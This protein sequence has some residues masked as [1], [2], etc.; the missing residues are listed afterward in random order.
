MGI[1]LSLGL[2]EVGD[3]Q[4]SCV[5][6][7]NFSIDYRMWFEALPSLFLV[8][9]FVCAPYAIVPLGQKLVNGNMYGRKVRDQHYRFLYKRDNRLTGNPYVQSGIDAIPD[10]E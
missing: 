10:A 6:P 3:I 1:S 4:I 2:A 9:A 7:T 8:G 5:Y